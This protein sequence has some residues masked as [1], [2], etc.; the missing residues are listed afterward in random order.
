[1]KT[2]QATTFKARLARCITC[3]GDGCEGCDETGL[4]CE[5]CRDSPTD[6]TCEPDDA[7]VEDELG[8]S[9]AL[10][11]PKSTGGGAPG[12]NKSEIDSASIAI[13]GNVH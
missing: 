9:L 10:S 3:H 12:E 13:S 2:E 5:W 7:P 8:G 6:C 4:R 1:M 11:A